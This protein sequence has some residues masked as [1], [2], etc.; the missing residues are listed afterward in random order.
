MEKLAGMPV[1]Q[2]P[3]GDAMALVQWEFHV[4]E[5]AKLAFQSA[6]KNLNCDTPSYTAVRSL[7]LE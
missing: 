2:R 3:T 7:K 4:M 1:P 6:K 5:I